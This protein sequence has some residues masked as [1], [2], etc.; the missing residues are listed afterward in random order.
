M[1]AF[2]LLRRRARECPRRR[3]RTR[4]VPDAL[5]TH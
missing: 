2:L 1:Y 3:P 4:R 5:A